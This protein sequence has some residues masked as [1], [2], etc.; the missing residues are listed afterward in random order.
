[1]Y[2]KPS[3][4]N[5]SQTVLASLHCSA[6]DDDLSTID[7]DGVNPRCA[8]FYVHIDGPPSI[9]ASFMAAFPSHVMP[10]SQKR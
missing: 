4:D 7:A 6:V 1:M 10:W 8:A 3:R 9:E 2:P 5:S